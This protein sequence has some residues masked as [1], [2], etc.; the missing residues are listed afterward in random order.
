MN[1]ELLTGMSSPYHLV[2]DRG[3]CISCRACVDVS[4]KQWFVDEDGKASVLGARTGI[5]LSQTLNFEESDLADHERAVAACPVEIIWIEDAKTG[6]KRK[7][8]TQVLFIPGK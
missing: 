8:T 3:R 1:R 2:Y 5:D 6:E 7:V 4:P